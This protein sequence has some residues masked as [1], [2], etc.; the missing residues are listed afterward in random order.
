MN[1]HPKHD[2]LLLQA[3]EEAET[4]KGGIIIPDAHRRLMNQ[5]I[6]LEIGTE[7]TK[8]L[9]TDGFPS[10]Q[11]G[12][13]VIFPMHSEYRVDADGTTYYLVRATEIIA[14]DNGEQAASPEGVESR[15]LNRNKPKPMPSLPS[16]QTERRKPIGLDK[17]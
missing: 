6:I 11:V 1:I 14:G 2:M 4:S 13:I 5:G 9:N 3:M 16:G 17:A 12:E 7:T 8:G 10:F 15:K